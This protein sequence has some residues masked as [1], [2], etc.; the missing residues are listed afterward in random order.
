MTDPRPIYADARLVLAEW[1]DSSRPVAS[2]QYLDDMPP[3]EVV[4][5]VSV[6]WLV[7]E[8]GAV[9]MLA[10]NLGDYESGGSAQASGYIRIPRAAVTRIVELK[11]A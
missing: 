4:Q 10:P 9:V 1:L 8:S 5:C 11:E 6:G 3:L 7:N 2:W